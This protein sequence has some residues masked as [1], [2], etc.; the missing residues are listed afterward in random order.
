[1]NTSTQ[2]TPAQ[3]RNAAELYSGQVLLRFDRTKHAYHVTENGST[4]QVR[5]ESAAQ[6]YGNLFSRVQFDFVCPRVWRN[7]RWESSLRAQ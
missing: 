4:R 3:P 7:G 2:P 6:L 5:S 1:M